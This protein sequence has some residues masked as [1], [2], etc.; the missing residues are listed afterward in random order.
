MAVVMV[1]V[2]LMLTVDHHQS[3]LLFKKNNLHSR[4]GTPTVQKLYKYP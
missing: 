3:D 4:V 2:L 1:S